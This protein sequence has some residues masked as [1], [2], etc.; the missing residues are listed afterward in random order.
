MEHNNTYHELRQ[1]RDLGD[2]I[3]LYFDFLKQNFKSFA[4]IFISYNGIFMIALLVVSYL[5]V[6]GFMGLANVTTGSSEALN[7]EYY[8]YLGIAGF[9][10]LI[11]FIAVGTLNYSLASS[12]MIQYVED[13]NSVEDKEKVWNRIT[14]NIGDILIFMLLLFVIYIGYMV[15]SMIL[16]FIPVL[17]MLVQYAVMFGMTSWLGISFMILLNENKSP[18]DA[19]I[20]G[21]AL[22]KANFWKCVGVNF[23]L[24]MLV[25]ILLLLLITIPGILIGAYSYISIEGGTDITTSITAKIVYT[26][27]VCIFLIIITFSQSLSQF[28]NGLLYYATHEEMYNEN[29]REKISQI[30]E[31]E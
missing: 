2:I 25:G 26:I 20:E 18:S 24:G 4:N 3:S 29:T 13:Q 10:F 23:I 17:G 5:L 21:W 14:T 7:E 8:I 27:G 6:S 30:G 28:I 15:I 1:Q 22:V 19:F 31:G 12:Y 11:V 16:A 9:L